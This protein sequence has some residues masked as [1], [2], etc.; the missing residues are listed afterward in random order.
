MTDEKKPDEEVSE[1]ELEDVAG[2]ANTVKNNIMESLR[3]DGLPDGIDSDSI[4]DVCLSPPQGPSVPVPPQ[5]PRYKEPTLTDEKK[6]PEEEVSEEELEDVAGGA[7]DIPD[8]T[9]SPP[10]GAGIVPIPY[11]NLGDGSS[12]IM[13]ADGSTGSETTE[14]GTGGGTE[15]SSS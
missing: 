14:S 10:G 3:G 5:I 2:G 15:T 4:P 13:R 6:K 12:P 11:P 9:L 7:F 8:V 1:E